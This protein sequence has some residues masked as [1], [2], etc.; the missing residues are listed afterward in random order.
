MAIIRSVAKKILNELNFQ[1]SVSAK[2]KSK[3]LIQYGVPQGSI[4][5]PTIFLIYVN[6][7]HLLLYR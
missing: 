1:K 2:K 7:F 4:S 6:C 5:G 3:L